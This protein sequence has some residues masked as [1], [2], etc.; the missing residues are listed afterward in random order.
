V[1]VHRLQCYLIVLLLDEQ[2]NLKERN[3]EL[4]LWISEG[5]DWP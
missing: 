3:L 1:L 5:S 4:Y 2:I